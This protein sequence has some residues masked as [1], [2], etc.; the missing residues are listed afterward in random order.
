MTLQGKGARV[1]A[2]VRYDFPK[3]LQLSLKAGS[4]YYLDRDEIGSSQ[5]RIPACHKEDISLQFTS[6]F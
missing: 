1:S 5:Q 2:T 4:L 6:K 3:G